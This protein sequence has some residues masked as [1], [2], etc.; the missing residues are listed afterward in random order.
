MN[1]EI[2]GMLTQI[3]T[4]VNNLS[5][6]RNIDVS[7]LKT[8]QELRQA[9]DNKVLKFQE[10]LARKNESFKREVQSDIDNINRKIAQYNS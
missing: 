8:L 1:P 7:E 6:N 10:E 4:M 5:L 2:S 9:I 3:Y